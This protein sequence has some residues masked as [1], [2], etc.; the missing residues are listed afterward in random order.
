MK[1]KIKVRKYTPTH[2]IT[3][4]QKDKTKVLPRKEKHKWLT[5]NNY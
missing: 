3:K 4:V 5:V 1:M 2:A